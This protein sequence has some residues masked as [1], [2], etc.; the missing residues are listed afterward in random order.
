TSVTST[1]TADGNTGYRSPRPPRKNTTA[2]VESVGMERAR[3]EAVRLHW[4]PNDQQ[5]TYSVRWASVSE[6]TSNLVAR[7]S[8]MDSGTGWARERL[9]RCSSSQGAST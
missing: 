8:M 9:R 4:S 7:R 3:E 2:K 5:V 6:G 1:N